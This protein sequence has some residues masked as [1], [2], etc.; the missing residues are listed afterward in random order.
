MFQVERMTGGVKLTTRYVAD[1]PH[2]LASPGTDTKQ[3]FQILAAWAAGDCAAVARKKLPALA[4]AAFPKTSSPKFTPTNDFTMDK[5]AGREAYVAAFGAHGYDYRHVL[6]PVPSGCVALEVDMI[7]DYLEEH[8]KSRGGHL[9][10]AKQEALAEQVL[11]T[12]S[13]R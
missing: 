8:M 1:A 13:I 9:P 7:G 10:E 3:R 5:V 2:G 4:A 12:L 11:G 6:V